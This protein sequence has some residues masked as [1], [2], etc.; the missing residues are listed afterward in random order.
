M[1]HHIAM[2]LAAPQTMIAKSEE[3]VPAGMRAAIYRGARE[4][5]LIAQVLLEADMRGLNGEDRYT[6]LAYQA[7]IQLEV[8]YRKLLEYINR[9]PLPPM[10]FT[11][12]TPL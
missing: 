2:G 3:S 7:L 11:D 8:T 4:S 5:A 6:V 1:N 10:L 12:K 9:S